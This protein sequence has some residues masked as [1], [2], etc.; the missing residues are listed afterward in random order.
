MR[1][2]FSKSKEE[3][4]EQLEKGILDKIGLVSQIMIAFIEKYGEEAYDILKKVG[5]ARGESAARRIEQMMQDAGADV[6]DPREVRKY[7]R[8][9]AGFLEYTEHIEDNVEVNQDG[10]VKI[11][12]RVTKCPWTDTWDKMGIPKEI[13][14]KIDSCI[15]LQGDTAV[16]QYF[17]M[18]LECDQGLAK[19]EK[20][21]KFMW[22]KL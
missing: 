10:K 13:Q 5:W 12:Y 17:N 14:Y 21:C 18:K 15:G 1:E 9:N 20:W 11:E 16:T 19:G 8:K 22:E 4:K 3:V 6:N 2:N 7:L